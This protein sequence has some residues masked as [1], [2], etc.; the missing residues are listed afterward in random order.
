MSESEAR[1]PHPWLQLLRVP[2]LLTV[3]GDALAGGVL[4]AAAWPGA[5]IWAA[6]GAMLLIYAGGLVLNDYFDMPRDAILRPERPLPSGQVSSGM[7]LFVALALLAAGP[8]LAWLACGS[9]AGRMALV[10]AFLVVAYDAGGKC[11]PVL[12]PLLMGAC[13]GG[14]VLVGGIAIGAMAKGIEA[15]FPVAAVALLYTASITFLAKDEA[16]DRRP[17]WVRAMLPGAM[18]AFGVVVMLRILPPDTDVGVRASVPIWLLGMAGGPGALLL[19]W[20][21]LEAACTGYGVATDGR[22]VPPSIGRLVRI[23]ITMQAAWI[24]WLLPPDGV[25]VPLVLAIMLALR[26]CAW[27][28]GRRVS[29]S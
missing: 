3:P 4:A 7:A 2:N 15:C 1:Q 11:V 12:G 22:P 13:R 25:L 8:V 29:G 28:L 20:A 18:L 5:E 23:M 16:T 10:V 6:A 17:G 19:I 26:L 21:A 9:E 24:M 14:S 27:R